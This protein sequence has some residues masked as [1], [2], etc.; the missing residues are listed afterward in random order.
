MSE[1][2]AK[3][4][5]IA[6]QLSKSNYIQT[7]NLKMP[8]VSNGTL[9]RFTFDNV[10]SASNSKMYIEGRFNL[11]NKSLDEV[12]YVG[13]TSTSGSSVKGTVEDIFVSFIFE[14]VQNENNYLI[15]SEYTDEWTF[16]TSNSTWQINSEFDKSENSEIHTERSSAAIILVLDC[17]S[18]LGTQFATAQ[19]NAKGFVKTLYDASG[20]ESTIPEQP[21]LG[22]Q[23][24][25]VNGVSFNMIQVNGGTYQM[26]S[27]D[28]NSNEKPVHTETISTFC[29]GE[30]EVTQALWKAVMGSN[31]SKFSGDNLPV[32]YVSWD[33]CHTFISKLNQ[34]T[35]K[36]FR[37]PTEAEWEYA[38]RGGDKSKGYTY[39]GSNTVGSVAW[40]YDNSSSKTHT[41]AKKQPNE[42]GLYDMSGNVYELCSDNWSDNYSSPRN[43]SNR[44]ARGGCWM[45]GASHCRVARRSSVSTGS[46]LGDLG[47]RLAL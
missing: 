35:G 27:N 21:T 37:L 12:K 38:A 6:Q 26:G 32:E 10:T 13:L 2:N 34:L 14:G 29:I 5:E 40:Y 41:V 44:V 24:F 31:P 19:S 3:F 20:N 17:S 11:K 25:T 47:L 9:V 1:V 43:S 23:T 16:V 42:L 45:G 39:S 28:G 33:D 30:T 36:T 18:S 15:R 8:G 7:I 46:R 22:D 4:Q